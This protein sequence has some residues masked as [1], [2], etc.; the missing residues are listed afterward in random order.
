MLVK[1]YYIHTD[2]CIYK[3]REQTESSALK[4]VIIFKV[5]NK[6]SAPQEWPRPRQVYNKRCVLN[7]IHTAPFN[8]LSM[9][10][11]KLKWSHLWKNSKFLLLHYLFNQNTPLGWATI[12]VNGAIHRPGN[13][14]L[15]Y[16]CGII[17]YTQINLQIPPYDGCIWLDYAACTY[18]IFLHTI[19][20][21]YLSYMW[22]AAAT[23]K[24]SDDHNLMIN[25][26]IAQYSQ[27]W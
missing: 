3:R 10:L 23:L 19:W 25:T 15:F 6:I 8:F 12:V 9:K 1:Y 21:T 17:K 24:T 4:K 5:S 26:H 22:S 2:T 16:D 18:F 13:N 11:T 27:P 7:R 14:L 20:L